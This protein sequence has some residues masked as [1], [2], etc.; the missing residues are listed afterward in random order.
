MLLQSFLYKALGMSLAACEDLVHVKSQI[1]TLLTT[2]DYME[3]PERQGVISILT[4]CAES[5]LDL[6]LNALQEFGAAMSKV[7]ISG[8]ISHLKDYCHGTRGKTRSTLMLTYSNV[9]VHAPKEQL[10]SR[11]EVDITG[12]VLHRYRTSCQVSDCWY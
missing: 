12:N 9:A 2:T 3:A 5:H 11:V 4:G 7:K 10:L 8:F 1:H 6:V